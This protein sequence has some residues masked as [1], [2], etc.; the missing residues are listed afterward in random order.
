MNCHHGT[1]RCHRCV[2]RRL[3]APWIFFREKR[4]GVAGAMAAW[5][6]PHVNDILNG[7]MVS[8]VIEDGRV[9]V[10]HSPI[11]V[12]WHTR[13]LAIVILGQGR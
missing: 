5:D 7:S 2:I 9:D 8:V 12:Q 13:E 1:G 4:V 3:D 10:I 11:G 6:E